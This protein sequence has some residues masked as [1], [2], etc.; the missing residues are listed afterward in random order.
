MKRVLL[1]CLV[2]LFLSGCEPSDASMERIIALRQQ[3]LSAEGCKFEVDITADFGEYLYSFCMD[4]HSDTAGKV[5]F[6]VTAPQTIRG[7]RGTLSASGGE[8]TFDD[9]GLQFDL[10]ADSRLSPISV[11]WVL[12]NTLRSGYIRCTGM[13]GD[14]LRATIDDSYRDDA[15]QLDFWIAEDIPA[16]GEIIHEGQQILSFQMLNFQIL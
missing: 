1:L 9:T 14:L 13:E 4:C 12:L 3:L 10:L 8:L 5:S 15:L 11:P 2:M 16:R 7:I 6:T